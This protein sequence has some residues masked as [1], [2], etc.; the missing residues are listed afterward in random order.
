MERRLSRP[1]TKYEFLFRML[2]N[3]KVVY[4]RTDA[5]QKAL[6]AAQRMTLVN[7]EAKYLHRDIAVL[8]YQAQQY[9]ASHCSLETYYA[10]PPTPPMPQMRSPGFSP[11]ELL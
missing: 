2:N 9:R 8:H 10:K 3:L 4:E 5:P 1:C 6:G 7:P 11:F